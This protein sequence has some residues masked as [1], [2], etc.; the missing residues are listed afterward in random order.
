MLPTDLLHAAN[1]HLVVFLDV[2]G[3]LIHSETQGK[4]RQEREPWK[5][6]AAI[7]P[8]CA[9][10][11]V[12]IV[13]ATGARIVLSSTIRRYDDQVVGLRRALIDAGISRHEVRRSNSDN[14]G[15]SCTPWLASEFSGGPGCRTAEIEAWLVE[16]PEVKRYVVV[17]DCPTINLVQA[18]PI[19]SHFGGG[20]LDAA[21][22]NAIELLTFKACSDKCPS[23]TG[24][25][26]GSLRYCPKLNQARH[27][28]FMDKHPDSGTKRRVLTVN[29]KPT[30][31]WEQYDWRTETWE[32]CKLEGPRKRRVFKPVIPYHRDE[33]DCCADFGCCAERIAGS[34]LAHVFADIVSAAEAV[35]GVVP[36]TDQEPR[37]DA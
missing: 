7:D 11:V 23:V 35:G 8:E 12:R 30:K 32:P 20:L 31:E 21:T 14:G 18:R 2:D 15:F 19:P 29:G 34:G 27:H 16:H 37:G 26:Y 36:V 25:A 9:A 3:V 6:L 1:P 28:A 24:K 33:T 10:R 22:D 5:T 13:R 4:G 17:D